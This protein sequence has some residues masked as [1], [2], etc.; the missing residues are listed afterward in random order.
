MATTRP[1]SYNSAQ[2]AITG[3]INIGTLCIGVSPLAYSANPGGLT[4]WMGPDEDNS[5]VIAKDVSTTNFP[6][7]VGNVG[8]VQFWRSTNTDL[9]FT[10]LVSLISGT[11]QGSASVASAWLLTNGY[12]TNYDAQAFISA[13]VIVDAT[14]KTAIDTLVNGLKADSLWAKMLAIYPFVGSSGATCKYNLKN[15]LDTDAAFRLNFQGGWTFS[16]NGA[17]PNGTTAYANTYFIPSNIWSGGSSS[18]S[19]YSRTNNVET[20]NVWGTRSGASSTLFS[21]NL[22]SIDNLTVCYH[23]TNASTSLAG[24][25]SAVNIISSRISTSAQ[26]QGI[27]GTNQSNASNESASFSPNPIYLSGINFSGT[28][29]GYSTRE[30]AFAHIGTGLTQAQCTSLYNRIQTFQTTLNRQV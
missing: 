8:N 20:G 11:T 15:P 30:L 3:T 26:I 16:A 13:A 4:W 22:N 18:M 21:C 2:S 28:P 29:S 6:T 19:A 24:T 25:T 17:T 14:E 23:N 5:Y 12:W 9:A 1:F 7:P 27:N 10:N